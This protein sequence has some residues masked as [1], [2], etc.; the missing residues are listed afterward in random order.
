MP[1]DLEKEVL[2]FPQRTV[3]FGCGEFFYNARD[4]WLAFAKQTGNELRAALC[5]E[6]LA[7]CQDGCF[8][9]ADGSIKLLQ[10]DRIRRL[11]APQHFDLG[12]IQTRIKYDL[13]RLAACVDVLLTICASFVN[14]QQVLPGAIIAFESEALRKLVT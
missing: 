9:I 14:P 4:L 2:H 8:E 1:L 7:F 13:D 6:I 12:M 3:L 5:G 11:R 10:P